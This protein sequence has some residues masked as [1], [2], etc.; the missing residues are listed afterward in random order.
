MP[1]QRLPFPSERITL[2]IP[3]QFAKRALLNLR[4]SP[5]LFCMS[6][7]NLVAES[8]TISRLANGILAALRLRGR[9]RLQSNVVVNGFLE[10]LFASEVSLCRLD[11]D[12]TQEKLNLLQ[13]ASG[14]VAQP[15]A[16]PA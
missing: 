2:R 4:S 7:M 8:V 6:G 15:C 14:L 1:E 9:V 5:S 13:F 16:G 3:Y 12:V 10:P 11:G